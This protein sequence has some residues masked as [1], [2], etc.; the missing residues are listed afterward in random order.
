[1]IGKNPDIAVILLDVVMEENNSGLEVARFVR[2]TV[3]NH[4]T[5]IVLRTGRNNFV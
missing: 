2:E 5:R 3:K 4:L 1:M